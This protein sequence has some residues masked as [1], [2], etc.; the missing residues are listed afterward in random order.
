MLSVAA[1]VSLG[2]GSLWGLMPPLAG[3]HVTSQ[4]HPTLPSSRVL[5]MFSLLLEG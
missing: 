5:L 3:H 4:F 1:Q 2:A